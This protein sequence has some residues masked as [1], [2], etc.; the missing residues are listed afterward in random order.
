[1]GL[2]SCL[3]EIRKLTS[4]GDEMLLVGGG[5]KSSLWRQI[6]ADIYGMNVVKTNI[7][8]QAAALGAAACAAVGAGIWKDFERIDALHQVEEYVKP[9]P[10]NMEFYN[11]EMDLY[12]QFT[13]MLCDMG[14]QLAK[15]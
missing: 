9:I 15:L 3:D 12:N 8:Q 5:S 14:D 10:E 11:K 4:V 7:D 2:R 1:M 13:D 6:Y